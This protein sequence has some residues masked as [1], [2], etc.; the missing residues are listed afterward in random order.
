MVITFKCCTYSNVVTKACFTSF[1]YDE[2]QKINKPVSLKGKKFFLYYT[3]P[4]EKF[5]K[6]KILGKYWKKF[7]LLITS[8]S[9]KSLSLKFAKTT[10]I[11]KNK[12]DWQ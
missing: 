5:R 8:F 10:L 12:I 3:L 1:P 11:I 2:K 4:K 7:Y 9:Q 6:F